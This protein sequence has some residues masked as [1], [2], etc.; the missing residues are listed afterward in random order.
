M[1]GVNRRAVLHGALGAT[2]A[3]ALRPA[4]AKVSA[5]AGDL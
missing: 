3:A 2:V 5:I 1:R 4:F